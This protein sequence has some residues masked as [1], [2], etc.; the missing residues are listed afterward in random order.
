MQKM[1]FQQAEREKPLLINMDFIFAH[2]SEP[3]KN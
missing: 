1:S 3:Y 2:V